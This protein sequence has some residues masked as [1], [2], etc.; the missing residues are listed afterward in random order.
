MLVFYIIY[1]FL[2]FWKP[3]IIK[4]FFNYVGDMTDMQA[5][6]SVHTSGGGYGHHHSFVTM[7]CTPKGKKYM[8]CILLNIFSNCIVNW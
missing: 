7:E 6:A 2:F 4:N 8:Y 1:L 3:R 5:S